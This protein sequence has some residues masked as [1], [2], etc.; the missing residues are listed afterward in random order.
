MRITLVNAFSLN[1]L[2]VKTVA[3]VSIQRIAQTP[4]D[5]ILSNCLVQNAIGHPDTDRVIRGMLENGGCYCPVGQRANVTLTGDPDECLLVA[6]Y[7]GPRLPE[8]AT[9]LPEGAKIEWLVVRLTMSV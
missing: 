4:E 1:M 2:S 6:Q 5:F 7:I 3:T 8:G 9:T